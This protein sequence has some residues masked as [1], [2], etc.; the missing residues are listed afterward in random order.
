M[1][2]YCGQSDLAIEKIAL[3]N[4][5]IDA[6]RS[7]TIELDDLSLTTLFNFWG[8]GADGECMQFSALLES[9]IDLEKEPY[10]EDF[11]AYIPSGLDWNEDGS[12]R[13][14]CMDDSTQRENIFSI[15]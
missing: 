4:Y 7:S 15:Q 6:V 11:Y 2:G 1:C 12:V 13:I 14:F 9:K 3:F 5:I 10:V 8:G